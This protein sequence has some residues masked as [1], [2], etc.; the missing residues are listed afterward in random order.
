MTATPELRLDPHADI[1]R[2]RSVYERMR[3]RVEAPE[4]ELFLQTP[5]VSDWSPAQHLYHVLGAT[6]MM[7]KAASLLAGE[8]VDGEEPHLR[9]SGRDVL[10]NQRIPR[11]VA[12]AP[13]ATTPPDDLNRSMLQRSLERSSHKPDTAAD[14]ILNPPRDSA[15]GL[16][17]L[18][19]GTLTSHQ[20]LRV[21]HV[22]CEHHLRII[23]EIRAGAPEADPAS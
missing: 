20:W 16:P 13:D 2:L 8:A 23:E 1:Q 5:S 18:M 3:R 9:E 12:T 10:H 11:G 21:A 22:H 7:L 19:W 17:H 14:V 15:R 4:R 6:A